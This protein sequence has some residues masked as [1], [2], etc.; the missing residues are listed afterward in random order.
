MPWQWMNFKRNLAAGGFIFWAACAHAAIP[1]LPAPQGNINDFARAL[2]AQDQA[3]LEDISKDLKAATGAELVF[4]IMPEIAPYDDFTYALALF[5][6]WKIGEKGKNNGLLVFLTLK[7]RKVRILPG[8]GLEGILPDGKL[9]R[10]RD[11]YLL[12]DLKQNQIGAGLRNIGLRLAQE[13]AAAQ[14]VTLQGA[15]ARQPVRYTHPKFGWLAALIL[16]L[17]LS[18]LSNFQRHRRRFGSHTFFNGGGGFGGGFGGFGGFGGSGGGGGFGGFG[19]GSTG[20]GGVG[21]SW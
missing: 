8:Y 20:G 1:N 10:F 18:F 21:G 2:S 12:P 7:E 9:G 15:A 3:G 13:I 4:V 11:E 19:G 5:G 16:F 14:G 6:A 17:A